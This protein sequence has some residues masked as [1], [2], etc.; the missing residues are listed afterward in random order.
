MEAA[1]IKPAF[2]TRLVERL[3]SE[4]LVERRRHARLNG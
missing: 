4:G 1:G 3:P 2:N